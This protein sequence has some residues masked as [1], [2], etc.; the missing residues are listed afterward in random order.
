[1]SSTRKIC[2]KQSQRPA[3]PT[4]PNLFMTR[5]RYNPRC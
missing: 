3:D 2:L 5:L 4:G 1:M